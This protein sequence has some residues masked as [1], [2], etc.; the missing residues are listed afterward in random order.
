MSVDDYPRVVR[1]QT[2]GEIGSVMENLAFLPDSKLDPAD[3]PPPLGP[4]EEIM[5]TVS[6]RVT[7][8]VYSRLKALAEQRSQKYTVMLR[9]WVEAE[10]A[11]AESG[12]PVTRDE[13][14]RAVEVLRKLGH[15]TDAA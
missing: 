5:V 13:A 8:D 12:S 7:T 10:L 6:I 11:A 15:V 3:V 14:L 4:D 9:S 2:A 1:P